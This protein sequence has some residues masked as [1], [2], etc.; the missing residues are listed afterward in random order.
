MTAIF[1]LLDARF[2]RRCSGFGLL[3][4]VHGLEVDLGQVHRRE[5]AA[6]DQVGH[7]AAQVG[8]DDLRAGNAQDRAH[9]LFGQVADF[10]N[11]ALLG[12]HQEHGTVGDLGRDGGGDGHFKNTVGHRR[13]VHT[14]LDVHRRL[15]LLKQDGRRIGLLQRSFL[16]IDALDL[17]NGVELV[18]HGF[19]FGS[20][21]G[22]RREIPGRA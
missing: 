2:A 7:I 6:L 22:A 19:S 18:S 15:V 8:V 21:L 16:E 9:L 10:K 4:L 5:A 14:Q 20:K 1:M 12:F 17:E 11:A 3:L 13:G